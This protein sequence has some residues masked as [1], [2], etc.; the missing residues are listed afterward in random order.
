MATAAVELH[1]ALNGN[2]EFL[3]QVCGVLFNAARD[4]EANPE[5]TTERKAWA[6]RVKT[7]RKAVAREML[8][9]ILENATIA[10][11]VTAA[12]DADVAYQVAT[13]IDTYAAKG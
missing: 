1:R 11:N 13:L 6:A 12:T 7:N 4:I 2:T 5:E 10:A 9:D 3:E 8:A